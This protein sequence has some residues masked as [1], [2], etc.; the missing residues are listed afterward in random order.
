VRSWLA[1][2]LLTRLMA[3]LNAGDP[4]P[5]LR[6]DHRDVRFRFPGDSSWAADLRGKDELRRWLQRFVAAGVQIF[7]DEVVVRGWPWD[8]TLAVRGT[9]HLT[10]PAGERVYENRYVIWGR[11]RWGLLREYEVYEDTQASKALD[12]HLPALVAHQAAPTA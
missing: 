10:T 8:T 7:A 5:L 3:R 1:K 4:E 2:Q 6:L 9:D 11:V 12:D